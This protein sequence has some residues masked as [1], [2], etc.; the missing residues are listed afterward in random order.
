MNLKIVI[1]DSD[2]DRLRELSYAFKEL[3]AV[4]IA[5]VDQVL[6]LHPP[7]GLDAIFLPL[8]AAERWGSRP[9]LG[10]TQILRTTPEDQRGGMPAFVVTDVAV[11]PGDKRGQLPDTKRLIRTVLEAVRSFNAKSGENIHR[12]GFWAVNLVNGVT[13]TQL[14]QAF[15]ELL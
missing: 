4:E 2:Q 9:I 3:G 13:P 5:K 11:R 7:S 8:P 6:Y 15:S 10:E 14:A 1:I 12:V